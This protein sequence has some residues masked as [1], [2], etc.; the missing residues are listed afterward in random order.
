MK[1]DRVYP[2]LAF[3]LPEAVIPADKGRGNRGRVVGL[4]LMMMLYYEKYSVAGNA[5]QE[6]YA[7]Y[8]ESLVVFAKWLLA[9]DYDIRLLLGDEDTR[10]IQDFKSLLRAR[11]GTYQEG[12]VI[13]QPCTNVEEILSELAATDIV[14][15]TRF[16]NVLLAL[17]LK[18]PVIAIS[19]HQK[20]ASLM[21]E[22]GLAEYCH[23]IRRVSAGE[24]IRQFQELETNSERV[25]HSIGQRIE[26]ER[27][28]LNEQY[29]L[30]FK[31][32]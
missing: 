20:C 24:L 4:G 30:F 11:L 23:D 32:L 1:Q 29:E 3:S 16:H 22:M 21:S 10:V 15:A 9:H 19:F 28:V 5:I 14:V 31:T 8:L 12:R 17:M 25:A 26:E 7:N 2:D 13:D 18:K 27:R 6:T